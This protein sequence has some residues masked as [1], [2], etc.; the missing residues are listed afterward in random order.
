LVFFDENDNDEFQACYGQTSAWARRHDNHPDR[1][2][3]PPTIEELEA[4]LER[5]KG[6]RDRVHKYQT[7]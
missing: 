3:V 4:A 1:I 6:W 2:Y 5:L 7:K